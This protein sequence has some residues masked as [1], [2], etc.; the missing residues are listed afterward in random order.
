MGIEQGEPGK[1][2]LPERR[3]DLVS[4]LR[5][6]HVS[7]QVLVPA[8]ARN[9]HLPVPLPRN[10]VRRWLRREKRQSRRHRSCNIAHSTT[11]HFQ[12]SSTPRLFFFFLLTFAFGREF[13]RK[14]GFVWWDEM[15]WK[16]EIS[17]EWWEIDPK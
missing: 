9:H 15:R 12:G 14:S 10:L 1:R 8:H 16:V 13:H 4:T 7:L 3:N 17:E 2:M 5:V 11:H 6:Q